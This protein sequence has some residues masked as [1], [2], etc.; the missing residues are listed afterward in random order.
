MIKWPVENILLPSS[1]SVKGVNFYGAKSEFIVSGSDCGNIFFWEK[2][3]EGIIHMMSGDIHGVVSILKIYYKII[4][5]NIKIG[6][7]ILNPSY[8]KCYSDSLQIG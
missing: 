1:I 6:H 5:I 3:T 7:E 4:R 8:S 2:Y